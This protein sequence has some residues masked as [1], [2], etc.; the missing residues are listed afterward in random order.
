MG[1]LDLVTVVTDLY[2]HINSPMDG[3]KPGCERRVGRGPSKP[4][5]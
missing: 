5:L 4:A 1:L 2:I 3:P